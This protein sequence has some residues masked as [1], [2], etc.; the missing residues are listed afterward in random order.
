MT[1]NEPGCLDVVLLKQFEETTSAMCTR[2]KPYLD[3]LQCYNMGTAR[4]DFL[5]LL[6]SLVESSPPYEPNQP[7]T[8]SISTP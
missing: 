8:A 3:K 4:S 2:E 5:P 7:A 6:M 1:W